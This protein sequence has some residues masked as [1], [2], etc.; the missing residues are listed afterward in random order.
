MLDVIR[1]FDHFAQP[2]VKGMGLIPS[3]SSCSLVNYAADSAYPCASAFL[4]A[5]I[6]CVELRDKQFDQFRRRNRNCD[7]CELCYLTPFSCGM[8]LGNTLAC[9]Q[10]IGP[11]R[12]PHATANVHASLLAPCNVAVLA[13]DGLDDGFEIPNW[14]ERQH[15]VLLSQRHAYDDFGEE[16]QQR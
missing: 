8:S 15:R 9:D 7:F 2:L 16:Y 13:A 4:V 10:S 14:D 12:V 1:P 6:D 5:D 11:F 3:P